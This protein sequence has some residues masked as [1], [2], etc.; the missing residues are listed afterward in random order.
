VPSWL[1]ALLVLILLGNVVSWWMIDIHPDEGYYWAWSVYPDLSYY[2]HP[3]MVG[4]MLWIVSKTI[5]INDV[6]LRLPAFFAW[7]VA[8]W[9]VYSITSS[10]FS[11][12]A[13]GWLALLI[14]SILPVF[15]AASHIVTPDS[16]L[17]LFTALTY[18]FLFFAITENTNR[19]W[20]L[21]GASVGLAMLSKYNTVLVPAAVFVGMLATVRGRR[22]LAT[23]RPWLAI[24]LS[25]FV[26][27][28]V[29][30]W[31][32]LHD[33]ASFS[34]QLGHGIR[35]ES[36]FSFEY[37]W[38][39]VGGQLGAALVWV[40][41]AMMVATFRVRPRDDK[42]A[43]YIAILVSGFWLPLVFFGYAGSTTIGEVNWPAMAYLPGTILL[44]GML[45][46]FI[47]P[48]FTDA[49]SRP[50]RSTQHLT[51]YRILA[52]ALV[53]SCLFSVTLVNMFRFPN[54]ARRLGIA[55]LP[56]NTQLS[57]TFG[58]ETLA[59]E[60]RA[61]RQ[62]NSLPANCRTEVSTKYIWAS[63]IYR[64]RDVAQFAILPGKSDSQFEFWKRQGRFEPVPACM[65]IERL[66]HEKTE[67]EK[68][69][70][71]N[72]LGAWRLVKTII[73]PTS[74]TPRVYGF[75]LPAGKQD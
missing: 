4:W 22:L 18:Y 68:L 47:A 75:Y 11:D 25:A 65:V 43:A 66:P 74:D 27:S 35:S 54:E 29:V 36:R 40:M 62:D 20:L 69:R 46:K 56:T 10:L 5:G 19:A 59:N 71:W 7:A 64:F 51:G 50:G 6:T 2:D 15:Q 73:V 58:W 31:N 61:F 13:H 48:G 14:Y 52:M 44:A 3:P 1:L 30:L 21:T 33:W 38:I 60:I 45:G 55:V 37:L 39:Y 57:D 49:R 16:P 8:A 17:L 63:M 34:Y 32:F 24:A 9:V 12:K 26:F 42:N 41:A 72:E 53:V 67:Y 70:H 28:P 23:S